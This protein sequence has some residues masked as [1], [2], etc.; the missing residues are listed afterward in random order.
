MTCCFNPFFVRDG[1]RLLPSFIRSGVGFVVFQSLLRQGWSATP[2]RKNPGLGGDQG[3]SIPS[4]SGM[5][6]DASGVLS[7]LLGLDE[8]V[9]IPSSSGM[10]CDTQDTAR[11]GQIEK[12]P[13]QSL[14]RQG[15]SAT[16]GEREDLQPQHLQRF[17]PFFV[18]DGLRQRKAQNAKTARAAGFNPFFVRDGLRRRRGNRR[19][20]CHRIQ[21]QSLLRQGWS[22]TSPSSPMPLHQGEVRFQSLLRQG[23]SAT[24]QRQPR[25]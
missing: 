8:G 1:L 23:W 6:C 9:S 12:I 24:A 25:L 3:V 17:N 15:W 2:D 5:V 18:R 13:F 10:V 19:N 4:S 20:G 21:F 11:G 14:L 7:P 22:A 16:A